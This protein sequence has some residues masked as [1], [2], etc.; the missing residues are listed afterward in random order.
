MQSGAAVDLASGLDPVTDSEE[1]ARAFELE[2]RAVLSQYLTRSQSAGSQPPQETGY[3][4]NSWMGRFH[5]EMRFFH[6]THFGMSQLSTLLLTH[7]NK[8]AH[9]DRAV[10]TTGASRAI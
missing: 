1:F 8:C 9:V 10:G 3:T 7:S 6:Q 5:H 4:L 2:R